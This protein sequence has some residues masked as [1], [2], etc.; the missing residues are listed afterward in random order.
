MNDKLVLTLSSEAARETRI[1]AADLDITYAEAAR[2][3]LSLLKMHHE[4]GED[5]ELVIRNRKTKEIDRI[6]FHW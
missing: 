4:L 3:G 1:L 6:K 5:E 2:R